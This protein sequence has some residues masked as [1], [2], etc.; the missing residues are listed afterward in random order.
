MPQVASARVAV[1]MVGAAPVTV[2]LRDLPAVLVTPSWVSVTDTVKVPSCV[3][4]PVIAPVVAFTFSP[5]G[6][7]L[8][9]HVSAPVWS[10]TPSPVS[11]AL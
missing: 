2:R 8:T 11:V 1:W 7:P 5:A 4:L 3:G 10:A 9:V 6:S